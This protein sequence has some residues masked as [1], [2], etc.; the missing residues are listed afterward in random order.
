MLTEFNCKLMT[1]LYVM[2]TFTTG[3]KMFI[4]KAPIK[5]FV[6]HKLPKNSINYF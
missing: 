3:K 2:L 1:S 4:K 5:E 6:W